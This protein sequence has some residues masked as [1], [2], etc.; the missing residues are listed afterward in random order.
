MRYVKMRV[1]C[2]GGPLSVRGLR[3]PAPLATRGGSLPTL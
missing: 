2:A 3:R 1:V